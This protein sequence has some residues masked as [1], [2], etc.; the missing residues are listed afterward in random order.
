[1]MMYLWSTAAQKFVVMN[2]L[3]QVN[4]NL[5]FIINIPFVGILRY[6]NLGM[7]LLSLKNLEK[8][9]SHFRYMKVYLA[10]NAN[11]TRESHPSTDGCSV[12]LNR[13]TQMPT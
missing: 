3:S 1:M 7:S 9:L 5:H 4:K 2:M 13:L 12:S 11:I 10:R 6:E 8:A